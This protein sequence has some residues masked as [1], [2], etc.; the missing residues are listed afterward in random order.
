MATDRE[1]LGSGIRTLMGA[2]VL[3]FLAPFTI[4]E[5]FKNQEHP[6]YIPV[7][8]LGLILAF[9]AIYAGFKGIKKVSD[10]FFNGN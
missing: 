2:L 1:L 4:Y 8:I 7:L 3:M 10:A 6:L 5:A 9:M